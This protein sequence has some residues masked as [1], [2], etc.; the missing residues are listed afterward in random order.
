MSGVGIGLRD[1]HFDQLMEADHGV[2]WVELLTDNFFAQGGLP[3]RQL[4]RIAE[5]YPVTLHCVGMNIGGA[6]PL[7]FDYLR[8]IR[9]IAART[10]AAWVSDHLCFTA[11]AGRH[12]HDLLPLPYSDE[13]VRH[14]AERIDAI[15][16][17]FGYRLVV[18]NVSAYL[19]AQAPLNEAEF[20]AAVCDEADC[21]LLLDV[22]N[23]YVNQVNLGFDA[24][25]AIERLPMER[26]REVHLAGYE[27]K[28]EYLIDA[29]NNRVS[30]PVWELFAQLA[31]KL[32]D[33]S[34]CIEWDN[35]IPPLDVLLDEASRARTAL[36]QARKAVA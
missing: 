36:A 13:A 31:G 14:V 1:A 32:T 25:R 6:D 16:D 17:F 7:D 34:V 9:E 4:D 8:S 35:D 23:L 22:N 12:Y 33:T 30:E 24:A 21:E 19:R 2:P 29:H 5:R 11:L 20:I 27:D 28:G 18:E 26:V 10:G 15:Q 3:P